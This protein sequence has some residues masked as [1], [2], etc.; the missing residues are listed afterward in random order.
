MLNT[1]NAAG[2]DDWTSVIVFTGVTSIY[3]SKL[4]ISANFIC[5]LNS[6][7]EGGGLAAATD[8]GL[9]NKTVYVQ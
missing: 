1:S 2:T 5:R 7:S 6:S 8:K 9:A 3:N 4:T